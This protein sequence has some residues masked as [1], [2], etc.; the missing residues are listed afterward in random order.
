M[1]QPDAPTLAR[2]RADLRGLAAGT[3]DGD[4]VDAVIGTLADLH[5]RVS[6]LESAVNDLVEALKETAAILRE[7]RQALGAMAE[8]VLDTRLFRPPKRPRH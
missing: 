4:E 6:F 5:I 8:E 3:K 2:L 1:S 7:D